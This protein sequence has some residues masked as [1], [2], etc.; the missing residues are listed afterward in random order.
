MRLFSACFVSVC[1]AWTLAAADPALVERIPKGTT[2]DAGDHA[3][4]EKLA[5]K[6]YELEV[7]Y[8][9]AGR[10]VKMFATNHLVNQKAR[11]ITE[12]RPG[13]QDEDAAS[14]AKL[15]RLTG[16]CFEKQAIT[17]KGLATLKD[18][19]LTDVRLHY[20][21]RGIDP[22]YPAFLNGKP[23]DVLH[24]KHNFSSKVDVTVLK[25]FPDVRYLVLDTT[26]AGPGCVTFVKGCPKVEV[27]ELHRP[28]LSGAQFEELCDHLPNCRWL[29]I[30]PDIGGATSLKHLAKL[31]KL[32][33]LMLSQWKAGTLPYAD[34]LEHLVAIK[35]LKVVS[36]SGAKPEDIAKLTAAAPHLKVAGSG[37]P[38]PEHKTTDG[39]QYNRISPI[40]WK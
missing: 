30:K 16:I 4:L 10:V 5:P 26:A 40:R 14:L 24:L 38:F 8:D 31:P 1:T 25:D 3:I 2:P 22:K 21:P 20:M 6:V 37:T 11:K 7:E 17:E 33:A 36:L 27:F 23:L 12:Q 29:E 9:A 28:R 32:E 39:T 15:S 13:L 34:G 18:L 19:P 35:G